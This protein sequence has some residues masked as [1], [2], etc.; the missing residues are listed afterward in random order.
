MPNSLEELPACL[1][2]M[3]E[4]EAYQVVILAKKTANLGWDL[5]Q[6]MMSPEA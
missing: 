2:C 3:F 6:E 5:K 1:N 4:R